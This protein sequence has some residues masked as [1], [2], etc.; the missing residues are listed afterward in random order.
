[1][2]AKKLLQKYLFKKKKATTNCH[3]EVIAIKTS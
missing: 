3:R 2:T 1:M